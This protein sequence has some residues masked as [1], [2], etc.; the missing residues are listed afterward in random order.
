MGNP[1]GFNSDSGHVP[2]RNLTDEERAAAKERIAE[3]AQ[4]LEDQEYQDVADGK[5]RDRFLD[6]ISYDPN[7]E[8]PFIYHPEDWEDPES[9]L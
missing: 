6:L 8:K 5:P 7:E 3:I 1:N 2:S 9:K 4:E